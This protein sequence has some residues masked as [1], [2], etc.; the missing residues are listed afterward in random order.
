V[1]IPH[2]IKD[3][4]QYMQTFRSFFYLVSTEFSYYEKLSEEYNTTKE[5]ELVHK[6]TLALPKL[7]SMTN[8]VGYFAGGDSAFI[9]SKTPEINAEPKPVTDLIDLAVLN[10]S[11]ELRKQAD[12]VERRLANLI[13]IVLE[14]G[15]KETYKFILEKYF[16][17]ARYDL[18]LERS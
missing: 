3:E 8:V 4:E 9:N 1:D 6:I 10:N 2:E 18:R 13:D 5:R 16:I 14:H 17:G 11:G 15:D 12:I 7:I